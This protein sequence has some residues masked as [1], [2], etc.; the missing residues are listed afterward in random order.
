[1]KNLKDHIKTLQETL[2]Q[3]G[4]DG[5]FLTNMGYP[6]DLGRSL[7]RYFDAFA[8]GHEGKECSPLSLYTYSEY[9]GE[10]KDSTTCY[11][12]VQYDGVKGF[13]PDRLLIE[14]K[15]SMGIVQMQR[16]LALRDWSEVPDRREANAMVS[17]TAQYKKIRR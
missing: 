8:Y 7:Q 15:S 10:E 6:D 11:F 2:T 13:S 16:D 5:A 17:E 3:K 14:R 1:M 4:F 9:S 12:R